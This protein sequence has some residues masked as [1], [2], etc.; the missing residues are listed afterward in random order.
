MDTFP[1]GNVLHYPRLDNVLL[2]EEFIKEHSGEFKKRDLWKSL[3][4]KIMWQTYILIL[5][6]LIYSGKIALDREGTIGWIWDPELVKK[7]IN[8]KDLQR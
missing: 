7:Y 3:P 6:Y 4:K 2:V 8:R 1:I 5:D